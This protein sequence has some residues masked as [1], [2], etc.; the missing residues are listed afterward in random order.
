MIEFKKQ[1][2]SNKSLKSYFASNPGE[3]D[4]LVNDIS[5]ARKRIDRFLYKNLECLPSYV[6]P[7]GI[8]AIGYD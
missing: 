6:I 3:K 4:I 8:L 5:Y 7:S 2:V 1:L